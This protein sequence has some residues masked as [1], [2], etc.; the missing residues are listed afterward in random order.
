[1]I[2]IAVS[3]ILSCEERFLRTSQLFSLTVAW[4]GQCQKFGG[5]VNLTLAPVES[6]RHSSFSDS[7]MIV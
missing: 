4:I 6:Y 7:L 2:A 5:G 1:M 3:S